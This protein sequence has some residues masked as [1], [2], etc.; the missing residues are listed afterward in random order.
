L[1][2]GKTVSLLHQ[3]PTYRN[4]QLTKFLLWITLGAFLKALSGVT[5]VF[6]VIMSEAFGDCFF[7]V[8]IVHGSEGH[9]R[10]VMPMQDSGSRQLC[11]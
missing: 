4:A 5:S 11:L 2:G 6:S 10:F 7:A 9:V 8:T 3:A 1:Q